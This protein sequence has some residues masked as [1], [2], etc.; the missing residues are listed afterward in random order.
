[1]A[2]AENTKHES[3]APLHEWIQFMDSR[4]LSH[5]LTTYILSGERLA[6][7]KENY[8]Q[9]A[10]LKLLCFSVT[11]PLGPIFCWQVLSCC[12]SSK[13][14]ASYFGEK[15][16]DILP[17]LKEIFTLKLWSLQTNLDFTLRLLSCA[18][19]SKPC[20]L[21]GRVVNGALERQIA[22]AQPNLK[23]FAEWLLTL[24]V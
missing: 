6:S 5:P 11:N 18:L 23:S 14:L 24:S 20:L 3:M 22:L 8:G 7:S 19:K 2:E 16:W 15:Y 21:I 1:M 4:K 10:A 13:F 17:Y 12:S 9:S